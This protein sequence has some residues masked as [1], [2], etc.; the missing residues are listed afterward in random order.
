MRRTISARTGLTRFAGVL[1]IAL[2][3]AVCGSP[4]ALAHAAPATSVKLPLLSEQLRGSN[5]PVVSS[6]HHR[7]RL[8]LTAT[9]YLETPANDAVTVTVERPH[10]T[11]SHAWTFLFPADRMKVGT[12]GNGSIVLPSA[13]APY[14]RLSLSFKAAGAAKLTRCQGVPALTTRHVATSGRLLFVTHST[15]KDRWGSIGSS[16][17][18]IHF[19]TTSTIVWTYDTSGTDCGGQLVVP[20]PCLFGVVW[21]AEH[22]AVV[23]SGFSRL[24]ST[25]PGEVGAQ[26]DVDLSKPKGAERTDET[27][28]TAHHMSVGV[29]STGLTTVSVH[30]DGGNATGSA[31]LTSPD[32]AEMSP[33]GCGAGVKEIQTRWPSQ[34]D[35]GSPALRLSEQVF[36]AMT[37]P[38]TSEAIILRYSKGL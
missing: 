8:Q 9:R 23:F 5:H 24:A 17:H 14:G 1:A 33:C 16:H 6:T 30:A 38:D 32:P 7:L 26:R 22:G 36:G 34:Y 2:A 15:G 10:D 18:T 29:G 37:M 27:F 21:E 20:N 31:V 11:E 3:A 35:H 19:G 13:I 25:A 28:G 12:K 4:S